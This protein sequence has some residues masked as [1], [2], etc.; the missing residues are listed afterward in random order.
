MLQA[1]TLT[2]CGNRR[3]YLLRQLIGIAKRPASAVAQALD[4]ALLIPLQ[5]LVSGLARNPELAAQRGHTFAVFVPNHEAH[6][7][8]HYRTFSPWHVSHLAFPKAKCVTY[9][10]G[11][12]I[13]N[14]KESGAGRRAI[15]G[16]D[17]AIPRVMALNLY[18]R[19]RLECE[20]GRIEESR[21]GEFDERRKGWKKCGCLI[22]ASGTL[23]GRFKRKATGKSDWNEAR[24]LAAAWEAANSWDGKAAVQAPPEPTQETQPSRITSLTPSRFS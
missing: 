23:G 1:G 9:V 3:L 22:F 15:T 6:P 12:S 24:V 19:H 7:F 14:L 17:S 5:N 18:R 16:N 21:S 4:A 13:I 20:A 2:A 8:I 10:S 11:R